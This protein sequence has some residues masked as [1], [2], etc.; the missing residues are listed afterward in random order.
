MRA[1]P[2]G[3]FMNDLVRLFA[4]S[5][6]LLPLL[7]TAGGAATIDLACSRERLLGES[8]AA[9][10]FFVQVRSSD[11]QVTSIELS[12]GGWC[13]SRDGLVTEQEISFP[14]AH[15][16]AGLRITFSFTLDKRSGAFEQRFFV[17]GK[18]QQVRHGSCT[19]KASDLL[20]RH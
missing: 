18:L 4:I 10:P 8:V 6:V 20:L 3:K 11:G 12:T 15:D 16:L 7:A 19:W 2:A 1:G 13:N 5:I 17:G 9:E 14:C